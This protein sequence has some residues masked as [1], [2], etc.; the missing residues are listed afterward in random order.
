MQFMNKSL[1]VTLLLPLKI[2]SAKLMSILKCLLAILSLLDILCRTVYV[3][4]AEFATSLQSYLEHREKDE[5]ERREL[6][7][8]QEEEEEKRIEEEKEKARQGELT[9]FSLLC[10]FSWYNGSLGNC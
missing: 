6:M 8:L 3:I 9:G 2:V 4:Q 10:G 7:R 5:E 1:C